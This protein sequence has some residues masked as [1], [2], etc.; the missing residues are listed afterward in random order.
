M[1][2]VRKSSQILLYPECVLLLI[3]LCHLGE[4]EVVCSASSQPVKAGKDEQDCQ[5]R[6]NT[7]ATGI[8]TNTLVSRL[9]WELVLQGW[10][11][12]K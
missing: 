1:L 11:C 6:Q 4:T 7:P 3:E 5:G 12:G 9:A 8:F 10:W 2:L